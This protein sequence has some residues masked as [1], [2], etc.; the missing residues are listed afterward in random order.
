M[1]LAHVGAVKNTRSVMEHRN[2]VVEIA[3]HEAWL[4]SRTTMLHVQQ[5]LENHSL[6]S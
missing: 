6:P 1:I 3:E 5:S 4:C 2:T